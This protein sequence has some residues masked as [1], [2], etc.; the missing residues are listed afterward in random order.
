MAKSAATA[1]IPAGDE[2]DV[3]LRRSAFHRKQPTSSTGLC[4]AA[5]PLAGVKNLVAPSG[6]STA[7]GGS[8]HILDSGQ[9]ARALR[10]RQNPWS[11][12]AAAPAFPAW[13]LA[14]LMASAQASGVH[15]V[16]SDGRKAAFLLEVIRVTALRRWCTRADQ[17]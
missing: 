16:E 6:R 8:R 12:L 17:A 3:A 14:I 10:R 4:R 15:L 1:S 11:D 7:C 13:F 9:P 5:A 2:R